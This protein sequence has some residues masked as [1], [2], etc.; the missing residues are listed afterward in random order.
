[1]NVD[2]GIGYKNTIKHHNRIKSRGNIYIR[3]VQWTLVLHWYTAHNERHLVQFHFEFYMV[4]CPFKLFISQLTEWASIYV[5]S[6]IQRT[7][8]QW[9][10]HFV[11]AFSDNICIH[12]FGRMSITNEKR[13]EHRYKKAPYLFDSRASGVRLRASPWFLELCNQ[14]LFEIV[15]MILKMSNDAGL[16]DWI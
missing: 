14:R 7:P 10:L 5:M 12:N 13:M 8:H 15:S 9:D 4:Q 3:Y 2:R 16:N 11:I 6:N 1:M